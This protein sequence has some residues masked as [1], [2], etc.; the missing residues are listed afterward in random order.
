MKSFLVQIG[1]RSRNTR[2]V[3]TAPTLGRVERMRA[4]KQGRAPGHSRR[5]RLRALQAARRKMVWVWS[6]V[7]MV[8]AVM[9]V[10]GIMAFWL[11]GQKGRA[12]ARTVKYK[13]PKERVISQFTSPSEEEAM[14]FVKRALAVRDAAMVESLFYPGDASAEEIV[15]FLSESE[16]RD[17][18]L[19]HISWLGSMNMDEQP[20]EGILVAH[21]GEDGLRERLAF[22]RP[23]EAGVWKVD[24]EAFARTSKPGWKEFL[25]GDA[26]QAQV[27][28]LVAQDVYFNG[29]FI[30]E[31]RWV[32]FAMT[33]PESKEL[34]PEEGELL[35]GYCRVGSAQA[36]ALARIFEEDAR[37]S[38]ATLEICKAEGA[39]FRQFEITRVL[40]RD[41]VVP[42]M[43]LDERFK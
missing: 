23:D 7:L 30:D 34:L 26:K 27:R 43:A 4:D 29:P 12:V 21:A 36:K 25:K 22:L 20:M 18:K 40:S 37:M 6:C 35:R 15:A 33:S 3:G 39:E 38:R 19:Q 16:A 5:E 31:S 17:G 2:T 9:V 32:C 11:S 42:A 41:W 1:V 28:V 24:F 13:A 8:G 10:G 14:D